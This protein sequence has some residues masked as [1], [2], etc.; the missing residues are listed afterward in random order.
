QEGESGRRE[1]AERGRDDRPQRDAEAGRRRLPQSPA[2][3]I[4]PR[5]APRRPWKRDSPRRGHFLPVLEMRKLEPADEN[6]LPLE[7]DPELVPGSAP[8]LDHEG[9]AV[10]TRRA[11]CALD[12]VRML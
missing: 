5:F 8:G 4:P 11:V 2:D 1:R 6:D 7:H 12:E 3:A 10:G 9:E